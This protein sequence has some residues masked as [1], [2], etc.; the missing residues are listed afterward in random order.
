MK[1]DKILDPKS[2]QYHTE[3]RTI[4]LLEKTIVDYEEK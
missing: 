3:N 1:Y 2:E 4:L